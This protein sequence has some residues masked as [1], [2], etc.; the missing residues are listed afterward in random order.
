MV[1][2][3]REELVTILENAAQ[4]IA[5]GDSTEGTLY[6]KAAAEKPGFFEVNYSICVG[7]NDNRVSVIGG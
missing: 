5:T 1:I 7:A 4:A 2:K 3:S 6:F